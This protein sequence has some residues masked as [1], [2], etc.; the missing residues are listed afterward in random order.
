LRPR[1]AGCGAVALPGARRVLALCGAL[2][3]LA[4][5]ERASSRPVPPAVAVRLPGPAL[6][7][8]RW[9]RDAPRLNQECEACHREI[10]AEWRASLHR[11]SFTV[12]SFQ[13]A[14]SREPL[15]FCQTC[16]APEAD[17]ARAVPPALAELGVGCT[18][19]HLT[20]QGVLAAAR[21]VAS[22]T[23]PHPVVRRAELNDDAA[24]AGCHEFAFPDAALR[25]RTELMQ[26]TVREHGNS[27][28]SQASCVDCH[29][30]REG[31]DQH[32]RHGFPASRDAAFLR[33][34]L[35][36]TAE[37]SAPT[38]ARL[39]LRPAWLGH[40]FPTGDLFR[41]LRVSAEAQ[42]PDYQ[43]VADE[44]RF[45][46]R[47]FSRRPRGPGLSLLELSRDDRVGLAGRTSTTVELELGAASASLPIRWSVA[48]QRVAHPG[49]VDASDAL[50][51]ADVELASG[52]LAAPGV[53]ASAP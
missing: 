5:G 35:V 31:P 17:P 3:G 39:E 7:G 51:E 41:R 23:A 21:D 18:T 26:S 12:D 53:P 49:G 29:M 16:H 15:A 10:A 6:E 50:V 25:G 30:P 45:L 36:V 34:A 19:C 32:R 28:E 48:Y 38:R 24:C 37:R 27:A 2:F 14:F 11:Q 42:G 13:A 43:R 46:T 8:A 40:A 4:C 33:R 44:E 52:A 20:E 47:H 22:E 1:L 9:G